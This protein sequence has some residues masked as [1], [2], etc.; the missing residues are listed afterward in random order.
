L[1]QPKSGPRIAIVGAGAIGGFFGAKLAKAGNDVRFLARGQTLASLKQEGLKISGQSGEFGVSGFISS[2][3]PAEIGPVDFII[4]GVKTWQMPGVMDA[5]PAMIHDSTAVITIQNGVEPPT[6]VA[7]AIG[8]ERVLP[9]IVQVAVRRTESRA[10]EQVGGSG[11]LCFAAS[12]N[13][14]TERSSRLRQILADADIPSP[15]PDDIWRD[16]W[17]KFLLIVPIGSVGA[18]TG[19][20]SLG[21]LRSRAGTRAMTISAMEEI[22]NTG[23]ALGIK[24]PKDAVETAIK[25]MDG[26]PAQLTTS[27]QRDICGGYQSE[28]EAWT[29]S[30][31]R[32]AQRANQSAPTISLLYELL[33]FR[34]SQVENSAS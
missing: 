18:A 6:Q 9:G 27:L 33:A 24:L 1:S 25:M 12:N 2:S 34:E 14:E 13:V 8:A 16:L 32:L 30:A 29:G 15:A 22:F 20:A 5:L 19:G 23:E 28:L 11:A 21:E 7:D 4:L 10:L 3:D 26:Q 31:M 17:A